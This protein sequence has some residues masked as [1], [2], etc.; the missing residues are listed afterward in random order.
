MT[1]ILFLSYLSDDY[2]RSGTLASA[3]GKNS[4]LKM[5]FYRICTVS[6][7]EIAK[8]RKFL[9]ENSF[10]YEYIVIMSPAH[11]LTIFAKVFSRAFLI[12]D[13]GWPLSDASKIRRGTKSLK[14]LK[15]LFI[16]RLSMFLSDIVILESI[17]QMRALEQKRYKFRRIPQVIYTGLREDRFNSSQERTNSSK[18][19]GT[20]EKLKVIFRGKYNDEAGLEFIQHVFSKR[21]DSFELIICCPGIPEYFKR[22]RDIT[23]I[24]RYLEDEEIAKLL[25]K[26]HLAINQ[27]GKSDRIQRS[28]AH[29]VF[30]YAYFG[31]PTICQRGS[32]AEEIFSNNQFF[33]LSQDQLGRFL[34]QILMNKVETLKDLSERSKRIMNTY[35]ETLSERAIEKQ[36]SKIIKNLEKNRRPARDS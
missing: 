28:I 8:L 25:A 15:D 31:I 9:K 36:F 3:L 20:P 1:R 18:Y 35:E 30:E 23:F 16:D 2:S 29:K 14:Y 22:N 5:D 7:K 4:A 11:F 27:F 17:A 13:A 34:D 6:V 32:A 33:Y 26:S 21:K 12:L 24:A 10:N 19:E